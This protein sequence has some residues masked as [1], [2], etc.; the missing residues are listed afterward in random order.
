MLTCRGDKG[1]IFRG[2]WSAGLKNDR[3]DAQAP[4][5]ASARMDL[6]SVHV[7]SQVSRPHGAMGRGDRTTPRQVRRDRRSGSQNGAGALRDVEGRQGL[8]PAP[9]CG[10]SPQAAYERI[11]IARATNA[12]KTFTSFDCPKPRSVLDWGAASYSPTATWTWSTARSRLV[13]GTRPCPR[14]RQ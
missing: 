7:P 5:E 6:P 10:L 13:K 2:R 1:Q 12:P 11:G 4:S 14:R 9:S 8:Q 3:K